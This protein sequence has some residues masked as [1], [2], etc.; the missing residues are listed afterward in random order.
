MDVFFKGVGLVFFL[1]E[2]ISIYFVGKEGCKE[3]EIVVVNA[4]KK[5]P[6]RFF[7]PV[8]QGVFFYVFKKRLKGFGFPDDRF[9]LRFKRYMEEAISVEFYGIR[10]R[11]L[12]GKIFLYGDENLFSFIG[13]KED[14]F[15]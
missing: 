9:R 15:V 1:N 4:H 13:K 14:F 12:P 6:K 11:R 3:L 7:V 10:I 2:E 5:P 8:Y